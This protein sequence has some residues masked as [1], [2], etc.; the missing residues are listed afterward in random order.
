MQRIDGRFVYAA[1]DLT[2]YLECRRLTE[3][4]ALVA[5]DVI[6]RP[7]HEDDRA[8]LIRRKGL[9]HEARF[10]EAVRATYGDGV[11]G[12]AHPAPHLEA[13]AQAERETR[14]AI[15]RGA[16]IIYQ[17]TFFDG[18]FLGHAD[19]LR[20]IDAPSNFGD[21][22]YEVIDTKLAVVPKPYYLIQLCNYSE[23]LARL[24]GTAPLYGYI[25]LGSGEEV[26]YRLH[27]YLAYYRHLKASFLAF[28][29]NPQRLAAPAP[30]E[31][32]YE[33]RHCA[34][35][36]WDEA[37]SEKRVVDDH[38]SRVAWMRRDQIAK[39]EGA[40]I[41]SVAALADAPDAARPSGMNPETFSKLRRQAKLQVAGRNNGPVYELLSHLPPMGFGLLP[42]PSEGDVFFDMEGDPW[43]APGRG[44]EYLF[45]CWMPDD[46]PPYRAFWA[47]D[48]NEEKRGF[49]EL[50]DFIVE[51]R[52]RYPAMHVYH[53]ASYEKSR[54]RTL[55]QVHC[56]RE[57]A[58]DELL[59]SEVLVDLYA[60]V[61][62]A[63]AIS[64]ESYSLKRLE[65]FYPLERATAVKKG[66][67]SIVMFERWLLD[68]DEEI[69][70]DIEAYNR[71]DCRSTYLLRQWL[72]ERRE[73][74]IASLRIAM[75]LR[76]VKAK[77][78]PCHSD[79]VP[80][81]KSCESARA[82]AL[83]ERRRTDVERRLLGAVAETPQ[84]EAA[85]RAMSEHDRL[86]FLLAHLLA[87]HRREEK[88][89]WWTYYDRCENADQ[90]IEF[91][92]EAI[93]GLQLREDVEPYKHSP[94][95]RKRLVFTYAF[96]DQLHKMGSG[97]A[98]DPRTRSSAGEIVAI[99]DDLNLVSLKRSGTPDEAHAIRELIPSGPPNTRP[100]RKAL[101]RIAERFLDGTL[102]E[103]HPATFDLLAAR[104]PRVRAGAL[105]DANRLQPEPVT[106]DA[107]SRVVQALDRS[108]L[109]VQGPPGSGK[110]TTGSQ[111]ICDLLQRG[112]RVGVLSTG[113]KAIHHLLHKVERCMSGRG[114]AFRGLYKRTKAAGSEF[115]SEL[116][117]AFI[118]SVAQYEAFDNGGYD[119]AGG[120][121]WLFARVELVGAFDYLFIDEAGQVSLADAIA[122]SACAKN[123]VLLGDPSQLAQ[124]SQGKHPLHADDSVLA[125][126][127]G[128]HQTIPPDRGIF[129]DVSYRMQPGICA[130]IS[131][132]MYEGRLK[133]SPATALHCVV[134]GDET[135]AG[136]YYMPVEHCD[137]RS[138]ALEEAERIVSEVQLL[139][140]AGVVDSQEP[141]RGVPRP[142]RP[143][144]VIVV[145]PYNAQRRLIARKLADAG[146]D[147]AV[148]TVDKFQGQEAAI[149]FYSM[150]TSSGDDVPRD[151]EFLFERNRFNVAISRA[152]A[153]SVLVCSPRLL[154][155]DCRTP[156]QMALVNLLCAFTE[157]A[158]R[159]SS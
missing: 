76:P 8:Q 101:Q 91:D 73:E 62:Q 158:T 69:L 49:E 75:P 48:R 7:S 60:V 15:A 47:L 145:T 22:S 16:P 99:D 71:D 123:V 44:L 89:A 96:P 57:D 149:V 93:G 104:A 139:F 95:D 129:L 122:V 6:V 17:A 132:A 80:G 28:V 56:T 42:A 46:D 117:V 114:A 125:H 5:R 126:V 86:T 31:Y 138:S 20:R 110:S 40:G 4:D 61:R 2:N 156:E 25:V 157:T 19:F 66:D 87:Y 84:T 130:F 141:K 74:A 13:L 155:T 118:E 33:R 116:P 24:A 120:T 119:L 45:G 26:R 159:V 10:L 79:F 92:R 78:A 30:L 23:H 115:T 77:D 152:R 142:L 136:L 37:C 50:V 68:R 154:E 53:Y 137:N 144:D 134:I 135:R 121:A 124:V 72:L 106:A 98:H 147:V 54:L 70:R 82:E 105:P 21:W 55:A 63:L 38:L 109:F 9:E 34:I 150:A 85:Y 59:R 11:V 52:Q 90:L 111:V 103:T 83:E 39:F 81:C 12:I 97:D 143:R 29:D 64:E 3:L 1:T 35:C 18:Q 107:V 67:D 36:R 133:P 43:Y 94:T 151:L 102:A 153:M 88:P 27:D 148:G 131:D 32:P 113:H 128:D 140:A 14:A 100:L 51:R 65:R 146:L 108:Y 58:I 41:A 127:L 112:Q